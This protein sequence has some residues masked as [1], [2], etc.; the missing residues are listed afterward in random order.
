MLE[1]ALVTKPI[2]VRVDNGIITVMPGTPLIVDI[3]TGRGHC[4]GLVFDI[5]PSEYSVYLAGE[6]QLRFSPYC[7][8]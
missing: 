1:I 4:Q 2:D 8:I 5:L 3:A 6:N 7:A